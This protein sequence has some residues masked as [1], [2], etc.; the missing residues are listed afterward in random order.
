MAKILGDGT[1]KRST[2]FA[3][4]QS[5]YVF[6]DRYG[7]PG[8]GNDKGKVEGMV[9]FARRTFMVPFPWARDFADLNAMLEERCRE[10]QSKTLRGSHAPIGERLQVDQAVFQDLPATP[11][12]ACDKRPGRVTSQALVRYKNTDYSV[13]VAYAHRDVMVK[14]YVDD[15]VITS[16]AE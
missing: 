9:E 16:G 1:R 8:K 7:R 15:V 4:L 11:F 12:D 10:R 3:A 13:P 5:D 6:E 2:L 14:G